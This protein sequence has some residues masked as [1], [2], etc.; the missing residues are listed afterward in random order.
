[1]NFN[2]LIFAAFFA[3]FFIVYWAAFR[4][5]LGLQNMWLLAGSLTFYGWWDWRFL[6]LLLAVIAVSYVAALRSV[7][8]HAKSWITA[9]VTIN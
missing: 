1:M 6:G 8:S 4:K 5:R 2:S 3:L 7:K 9:G